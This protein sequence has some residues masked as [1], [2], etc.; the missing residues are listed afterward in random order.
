[1]AI[2]RRRT[3]HVVGLPESIGGSGDPSPLT[4]RGVEAAIRACCERRFGSEDLAGRRICVVGL[5]HV[6]SHLAGRL[7]AGGA[8]V[9]AADID[10]S[11]RRLA[12]RL[13]AEMGRAGGVDDLDLRR[14]RAVRTRGAI[15]RDN[16]GA[17]R[18]EIVCGVGE[19]RVGRATPRRGARIRAGSSTPL[20]SSRTPAA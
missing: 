15:D 18:C 6:G 10:P 11:K 9:V 3:S 7:L 12:H 5:G 2:D 19:Q 20:T 14:A 4:A 8:E 13:G 1:M 16:L 17:L